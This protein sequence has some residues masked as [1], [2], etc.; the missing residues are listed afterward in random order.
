LEMTRMLVRALPVTGAILSY[1]HW[2]S[3]E[4]MKGPKQII[5]GFN[6][7]IGRLTPTHMMLMCLWCVQTGC[8]RYDEGASWALRATEA[9]LSCPHRVSIELMKGPKQIIC[10]NNARIGR[11]TPTHM[12]LMCLWCVKT[13][14][15]GDDEGASLGPPGNWVVPELPS[16][17]LY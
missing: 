17:G 3:N 5:C 14:C 8:L 15:L 6:A 13:G 16:S 4:L 2:V 12:M 1:L 7:R 9:F 10:G 11:L